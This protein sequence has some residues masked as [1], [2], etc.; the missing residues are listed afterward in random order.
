MLS[1]SKLPSIAGVNST[2][3]V[4]FRT[5]SLHSLTYSLSLISLSFPSLPHE[6][7][8]IIIAN[9]DNEIDPDIL[10]NKTVPAKSDYVLGA[11]G[12]ENASSGCTGSFSLSTTEGVVVAEIAY[13]SPYGAGQ[14]TL[15]CASPNAS[16]G[17]LAALTDLHITPETID[18]CK[19]V[20]AYI[21]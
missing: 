8:L 13:D 15:T 6:S 16:K 14:P 3:I 9:K 4:S 20:I 1:S 12:R 2:P 21:G 19:L 5:P 17:W 7:K 11:C 10:N 18:V